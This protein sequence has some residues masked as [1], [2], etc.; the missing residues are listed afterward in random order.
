MGEITDHDLLVRIDTAVAQHGG[1]LRDMAATLDQ[2]G[3]R[4]TAIETKLLPTVIA[5]PMPTTAGN[6]NGNSRTGI[7]LALIKSS[8]WALVAIVALILAYMYLNGGNIPTPLVG[9]Q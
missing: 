5:G 6:G 2:H 4:L 9:A 3:N 1:T 7:I 8:P